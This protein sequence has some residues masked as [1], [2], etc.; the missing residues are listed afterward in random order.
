MP[1][2][3]EVNIIDLT[4][5]PSAPAG[6]DLVMFTLPDGTT[7]FRQWSSVVLASQPDDEEIEA[8]A[9]PDDGPVVIGATTITLSTRAN[10][11][12]RVYRNGVLQ[13]YYKGEVAL[14][15]PATGQFTVPV[16]L[17]NEWFAF[18]SY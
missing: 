15:N 7:F 4:V 1:T 18:Q 5:S 14:S 11:R 13:S 6:T 2:E 17:E 9:D 16:I 12:T 10:R 3:C 8:V